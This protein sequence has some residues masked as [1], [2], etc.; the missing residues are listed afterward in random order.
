MPAG[1]GETGHPVAD[2]DCVTCTPPV[3]GVVVH[4]PLGVHSRFAKRT[5]TMRYGSACATS[6]AAIVQPRARAEGAPSACGP[7]RRVKAG[8]TGSGGL[9]DRSSAN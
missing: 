3:V 2:D 6:H 5:E 4:L 1:A 9:V 7:K 8:V